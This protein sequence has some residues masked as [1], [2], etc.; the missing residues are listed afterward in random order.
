[1]KLKKLVS[2]KKKIFIAGHKGMVG[3]A[4]I[5]SLKKN[6]K[7]KIY[8]ESKKK[9]NLLNQKQVFNY[10]KKVRPDSVV[11][12]AAKVGGIYANLN[13]KLTFLYD[14]L[15][16]QNNLIY[17]SYRAGVKNLIF[18]GSSCIYPKDSKQPIKESYLLTGPLEQTNDAYAIAKI[19]GLKLCQYLNE[20]YNL[21]YKTLMPNN[22]YGPGDSY[23]SKNSHFFSALIKKT[24]YSIIKKKNTVEIW[25][26]GKPLREIMY[27][28]DLANACI[29]FLNKKTKETLINIGSGIELSIEGYL[30]KIFK[31]FNISLK[32]IYNK[33]MPDGMMRKRLD[34]SI[35]KK[36]G[37]KSQFSL[38]D[39]IKNTIEDYI[40][41]HNIKVSK[42]L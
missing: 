2:R 3:S 26:S 15:Q 17:G 18:L 8:T 22:L 30:K 13:N 37:W 5:R 16:I 32:I 23:D 36:Y 6:K 7:I 12:A 31:Y 1:M 29:F 28:D 39:G 24:I 14:N 19:S 20:K 4:I 10:L 21:N 25:G 34:L 40:R 11:I 33:K 42:Y 38:K 41:R 27:V 35:C 9:L